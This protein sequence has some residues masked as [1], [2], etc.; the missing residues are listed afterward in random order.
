MHFKDRLMKKIHVLLD[1]IAI[2]RSSHLSFVALAEGFGARG[3]L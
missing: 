1:I 2:I 3:I